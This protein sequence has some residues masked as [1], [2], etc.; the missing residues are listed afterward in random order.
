MPQYNFKNKVTTSP[1]DVQP[2]DAFAIKVVAVA[3]HRDDWTAYYGP[4]HWSN[5]MVADSGDKLSAGQA[6]PLFYVLAA[7]GRYYRE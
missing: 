7:S 6:E 5:E 2:D 4:S 3:G 1:S